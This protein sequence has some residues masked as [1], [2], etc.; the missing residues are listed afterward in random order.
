[1]ENLIRLSK[2]DDLIIKKSTLYKWSA[3]GI[4]PELF[5]KIQGMIFIDLARLEK[6]IENSRQGNNDNETEM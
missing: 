2:A 4:N 6:L 1:M 3:N 5:I